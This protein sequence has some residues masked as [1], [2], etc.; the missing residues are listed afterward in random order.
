MNPEVVEK[1]TSLSHRFQLIA[2]QGIG[3]RFFSIFAQGGSVVC[4]LPIARYQYVI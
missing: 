4:Q 1:I 2:A 3:N